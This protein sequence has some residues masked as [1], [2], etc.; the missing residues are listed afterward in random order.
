MVSGV[1]MYMIAYFFMWRYSRKNSM[2]EP[3]RVRNTLMVRG[4]P[5]YVEKSGRLRFIPISLELL[6]DA[7]CIGI[8]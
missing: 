6:N 2:L 1:L 7:K 5:L 4:L 8:S 3:D